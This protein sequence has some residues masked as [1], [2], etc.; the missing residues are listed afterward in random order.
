M[1]NVAHSAKSTTL[2][3]FKVALNVYHPTSDDQASNIQHHTYQY[4]STKSIH[5]LLLLKIITKTGTTFSSIPNGVGAIGAVPTFGWLQI[6]GSIGFWD[7]VGML[8]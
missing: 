6:I 3:V 4:K 5:N 2:P 7:L 1:L 8:L